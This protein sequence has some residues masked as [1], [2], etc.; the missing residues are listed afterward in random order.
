MPALLVEDTRYC[1]RW[2]HDKGLLVLKV[3]DDRKCLKFKTRSS[4]Y[5]NRFELL[6]R[7]LL[8]LSSAVK[9]KKVAPFEVTGAADLAYRAGA[10]DEV[11]TAD[12]TSLGGGTGAD[13]A[14]DGAAQ[15]TKA[16]KKKK[17]KKK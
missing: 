6:S 16:K 9:A 14:G 12:K 13:M 10:D 7:E 8:L 15:E 2:R 3:T 1:I 11:G 17:G 5:L 4:S